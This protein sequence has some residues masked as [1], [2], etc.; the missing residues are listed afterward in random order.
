MA[1][2]KRRAEEKVLMLFSKFVNKLFIDL[3]KG[4]FKYANDLNPNRLFSF[5][6]IN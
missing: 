4:R 5:V 1:P 6:F 2:A 3:G